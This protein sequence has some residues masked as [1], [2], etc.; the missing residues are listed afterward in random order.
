LSRKQFW[1]GLLA[2]VLCLFVVSFVTAALGV[3]DD[4]I[5]KLVIGT[6]WWVANLRLIYLRACD[7]GYAKPGW[8][9]FFSAFVPFVWIVIASLRTG[10]RT[11]CPIPCS[12]STQKRWAQDQRITA[13]LEKALAA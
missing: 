10:S 8:M 12:P 13:G 5:V 3:A 7:V 11:G 4:E 1:L 9:T 2:L 6:A